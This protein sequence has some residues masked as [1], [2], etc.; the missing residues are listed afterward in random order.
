LIPYWNMVTTGTHKFDQEVFDQFVGSDAERE[1]FRKYQDLH[2]PQN[3]GS[4]TPVLRGMYH[5]Q[6][7]AW[8]SAFDRSCF[9]VIA[10]ERMTQTAN[11]DTTNT[12]S[13]C[14]SVNATMRHAFRHL[15]L[16][17]LD[18]IEDTSA[19]NTR[20]YSHNPI[21]PHLKSLL[22]DFYRPQNEYL[23]TFMALT[24]PPA[25][26]N[27]DDSTTSDSGDLE[28]DADYWKNVWN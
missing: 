7:R 19:K 27:K 28:E 24:A 6:L 25:N 12:N 10:L 9:H 21:P 18:H 8:F 3:T 1:A 26:N 20:A 15:G 16:P 13:Q 5:L 11:D 22:D 2:I 23:A 17:P 14:C 4:H